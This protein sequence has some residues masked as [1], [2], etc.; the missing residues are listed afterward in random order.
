ME[1]ITKGYQPEDALRYFEEIAQIP[2]GSYN[3]EAVSQYLVDFAAAHGIECYRDELFNVFMKKPGSKGCENL[4]PI[5]I[6]G[7]TDMVCEKNN[8]TVHDFTKDP[9]KLRIEDGW[10]KASRKT[11]TPSTTSPRIL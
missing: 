5:L 7:H 1:Y 4:P 3:E 6:Q 8:D 11:T 9:L 10:L 2:H